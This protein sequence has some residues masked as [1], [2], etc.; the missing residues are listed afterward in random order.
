[1]A[2]EKAICQHCFENLVDGMTPEEIEL[3]F[4]RQ[5]SESNN[6]DPN[7]AISKDIESNI[8]LMRSFLLNNALT[9]PGRNQA[10]ESVPI[11]ES[12]KQKG[13]FGTIKSKSKKSLM[14]MKN[15]F[16]RDASY[17]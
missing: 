14:K 9:I 17:A 15:F 16:K 13:K 11:A 7:E 8:G 12:S 2:G 10:E 4:R 6:I 1:M 5:R 3:N